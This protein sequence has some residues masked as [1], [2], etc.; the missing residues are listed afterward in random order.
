MRNLSLIGTFKGRFLDRGGGK[1]WAS[2]PQKTGKLV[3]QVDGL[4]G[5]GKRLPTQLRLQKRTFGG[6]F[7]WR[8]KSLVDYCRDRWFQ[9]IFFI[10]LGGFGFFLDAKI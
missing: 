3:S 2:W 5:G 7:F 9:E 8:G 6:Y 1:R 10:V 4:A